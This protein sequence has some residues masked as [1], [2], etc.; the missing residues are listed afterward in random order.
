MSSER[1]EKLSRE[2]YPYFAVVGGVGVGKSELTDLLGKEF[3][4]TVYR[5]DF[6]PNPHLP[7]FYNGNPSEHAFDFQMYFLTEDAKQMRPLIPKLRAGP[8]VHDQYI[9]G[10]SLFETLLW[11]KMNF[12]SDEEN[13]TYRSC[14]RALTRGNFLPKADIYLGVTASEDTVI[15]RIKKRGR[16]MELTMHQRYPDYFPTIVRGFNT[17]FK[18]LSRNRP[19]IV[20][21]TDKWDFVNSARA[22]DCVLDE[23]RAWS[24]YY[25]SNP[26]RLNRLGRDGAR[27]ILPEF[28]K[29]R[30]PNYFDTTPGLSSEQ[31]MLQRR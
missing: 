2:R 14:F 28:L 21:D 30:Y 4:I 11:L 25:I 3:E 20:I 16:E 12:I 9:E 5:E 31:K 27:I 6:A 1:K 18:M 19:V 8:I 17:W 7:L 29:Y 13:S 15:E 26:N 22:A 10:D 24:S 23:V